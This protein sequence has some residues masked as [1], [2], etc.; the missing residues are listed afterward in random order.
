MLRRSDGGRD[1]ASR[2]TGEFG[3]IERV[4]A[5]L[6]YGADDCLL[7]P[8]DDAA[9]G[10]GRRT[11]GWSPPPT[12]W[13]RAGTSGATGPPRATSGTGRRRRTWPTSRRWARVPTA[14]L[15]G[16]CVPPD[17]DPR[18]AEELADGLGAEAAPV[19][20]A[21]GRRRHV[22]QPDAHHRGDRARRPGRAAR[23][24]CAPAPGRATWSRWPAGSGTRRPG[25]TVL[26]R[27]FRYARRLLV[28]AYRRPQ[29]PYAAGPAA[30]AARRHLHDRRLGRAARRPRARRRR[31][32]ASASTCG[33]TPSRC[34]GRCATRRGARCRPVHLGA[35]RWRRP[36]RWWPPSRADG[37]AAG[38]LAADRPGR[39]TAPG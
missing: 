6:A 16:L 5:R 30:A 2:P 17:L 8:G 15:V 9:R 3:L 21:R 24:C 32:A 31:P 7:G 34:P 33:G 25:Y 38:G 39:S 19:G 28:E 13:S 26:S 4:T 18:W 36:R 12:C 22:R 10:G 14:L 20:A 23:R 1:D 29:V 35:G 11:A 37:G 27:G